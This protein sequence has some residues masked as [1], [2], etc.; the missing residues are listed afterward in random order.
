MVYTYIPGKKTVSSASPLSGNN[1]GSSKLSRSQPTGTSHR[2]G[3][4][5]PDL[6]LSITAVTGDRQ[7]TRISRLANSCKYIKCVEQFVLSHPPHRKFR[8]R[9][10]RSHKTMSGQN[11]IEIELQWRGK[12]TFSNIAPTSVIPV[13]LTATTNTCMYACMTL[14]IFSVSIRICIFKRKQKKVFPT[15]FFFV[16]ETLHNKRSQRVLLCC[17]FS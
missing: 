11:S 13:V 6:P 14:R 17:M 15:S 1:E 16:G 10:R 2:F 3:P 9:T 12:K 5:A 4:K 8:S 7:T